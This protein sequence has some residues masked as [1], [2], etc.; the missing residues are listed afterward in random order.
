MDTFRDYLNWVTLG[1]PQKSLLDAVKASM[2]QGWLV[3]NGNA[4]GT[5]STPPIVTAI[6]ADDVDNNLLACEALVTALGIP[7]TMHASGRQLPKPPQPLPAGPWALSDGQIFPKPYTVLAIKWLA[8]AAVRRTGFLL[9]RPATADQKDYAAAMHEVCLQWAVRYASANPYDWGAD[10]P[11]NRELCTDFPLLQYDLFSRLY[12]ASDGSGDCSWLI[13]APERPT[14]YSMGAGSPMKAVIDAGWG[15][16]ATYNLDAPF[17]PAERCRQLICWSVDW[18][19]YEDFE[20]APAGPMDA[21]AHFLG[22]DGGVQAQEQLCYH[23]EADYFFE[24]GR[25]KV[26]DFHYA[27]YQHWTPTLDFNDPA[28]KQIY[29]G[30]FGADRNGNGRFDLGSVPKSV[31]LRAT[32]VA[33]FLYYDRRVLA[34]FDH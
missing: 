8:H 14:S 27:M 1:W 4:Y 32:S 24:P 2:K 33:R 3:N 34:S 19:S 11:L 13:T 10:R 15:D 26:H 6:T 9:D 29:A 31:R 5:R 21:S 18:R 28:W 22:S 17:D 30:C 12:R 25:S 16:F 23:P 7:C 20:S